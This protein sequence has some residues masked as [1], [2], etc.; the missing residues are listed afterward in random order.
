MPTTEFKIESSTDHGRIALVEYPG[1]DP[2]DNTLK[3]RVGSGIHLAW[4]HF[5]RSEALALA[6][7]L[8]AIAIALDD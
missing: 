3:L 7:A 1:D 6:G 5:T 8:R 2:D 4:V